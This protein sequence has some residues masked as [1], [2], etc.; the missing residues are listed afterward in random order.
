MR[1]LFISPHRCLWRVRCHKRQESCLGVLSCSHLSLSSLFSSQPS[2][3]LSSLISAILFCQAFIMLPLSGASGG[4]TPSLSPKAPLSP[5]RSSRIAAQTQRS[6]ADR[7]SEDPAERFG[8][9][10]LVVLPIPDIDDIATIHTHAKERSAQ[11]LQGTS[12]QNALIYYNATTAHLDALDEYPGRITFFGDEIGLVFFRIPLPI[13]ETAH[14]LLYSETFSILSQMGLKDNIIPTGAATFKD[15]PGTKKKQGDSG[16]RPR[17]PR[18]AGNHFPTLVIEAGNSDSHPQLRKDRDVW[19]DISPPG[20]PR[21]DVK[22]VLL[23]KVYKSKR[24]VV[25]QWHRSFCQSP[26]ASV[27]IKPHPQRPFSLH[28]SSCWLIKG[29]PMV[30]AFH[31]VFLGPTQGTETDIVLTRDFFARLAMLCWESDA[32]V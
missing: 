7:A 30:I 26:T 8:L 12:T 27:E 25:E 28:D 20:Q 14:L 2:P 31:E 23:I 9:A 21:G 15:P 5:R 29:A 1:P 10:G 16:F 32:A 22:M 17:P 24:I 6:A 4:K 11:L 19:F 3:L 18:W 13:H